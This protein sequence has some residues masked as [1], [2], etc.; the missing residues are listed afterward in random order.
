MSFRPQRWNESLIV[1]GFVPLFELKTTFTTT[2]WTPS[3]SL[4][5]SIRSWKTPASSTGSER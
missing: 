2:R 1:F 3:F 5:G 4:R